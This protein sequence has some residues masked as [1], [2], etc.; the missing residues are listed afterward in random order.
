[1]TGK[2]RLRIR[3]CVEFLLQSAERGELV[4]TTAKY[5]AKLK[6]EVDDLHTHISLLSAVYDELSKR[7][8]VT[9]DKEIISWLFDP[10]KMGRTEVKHKKEAIY[11]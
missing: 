1:M 7:D 8:D 6:N 2:E 9:E 10:S 5:L 4:A 3:K 11:L